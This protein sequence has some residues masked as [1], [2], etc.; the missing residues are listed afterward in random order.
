MWEALLKVSRGNVD[1]SL[2]LAGA[3]DK[4]QGILGSVSVHDAQWFASGE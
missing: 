2:E 4:I 3:L 1:P